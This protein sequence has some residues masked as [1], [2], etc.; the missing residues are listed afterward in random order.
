[1]SA[2]AISLDALRANLRLIEEAE[3]GFGVQKL[4]EGVYGFAYAPAN[5]VA[6]LFRTRTF[7]GYEIHKRAG[8]GVYILGYVTAGTAAKLESSS[9]TVHAALFAEAR[10]EAATLVIIDTTRI[11]RFKEHSQREGQGLQV[12]VAP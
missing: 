6:P 4:P 11:V 10:G 12:E 1:M 9:E 3:E 8:G 5:R 7:G 2:D